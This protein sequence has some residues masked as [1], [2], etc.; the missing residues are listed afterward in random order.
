ML[1]TTKSFYEQNITINTFFFCF[2]CKIQ[3]PSVVGHEIGGEVLSV[4]KNVIKFKVGDVVGVGYV[5][6]KICQMH[7]IT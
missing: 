6:L 1:F 3:Y 4:G 5:L 7:L 2:A